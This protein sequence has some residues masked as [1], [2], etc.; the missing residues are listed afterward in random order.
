MFVGKEEMVWTKTPYEHEGRSE[1]VQR[2]L[3][4]ITKPAYFGRSRSV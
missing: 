4:T 2:R 3:F 1:H